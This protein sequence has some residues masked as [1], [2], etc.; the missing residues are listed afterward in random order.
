MP[1]APA[2]GNAPNPAN[3]TGAIVSN[4]PHRGVVAAERA[5]AVRGST[6]AAILSG[7]L[8]DAKP[9]VPSPA[10][11]GAQAATQPKPEVQRDDRQTQADAQTETEAET[12]TETAPDV[13]RVAPTDVD[14]DTSKRIAK[15]QEAERHKASSIA[16][17]Q[18]E[19]DKRAKA[20]EGEWAPRVKRA[21]DFEALVA[22]AAKA[23]SNP[24][25]LAELLTHL[26]YTED[27]F[28]AAGQA[29]YALSKA[30]QADPARK[31][32]AEKLMRDRESMSELEQ[33][34][35][36]VREL[37]DGIT[38]DK[39][40]Q[41]FAQQQATFLDHTLKAIGDDAP[42]AKALVT[43]NPTKLRA[44]LWATTVELTEAN[45]GDVP[46]FPEIVAAYEASRR[47]ELE[48]L[49]LAP[50]TAPPT[51]TPKKN[52]QPAEEKNTAR[53]L[54]N[55]LSTPRVPRPTQSGDEGRKASRKATLQLIE[56]GKLG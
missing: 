39:Q 12:P 48:E 31:A 56:S 17:K 36:E 14:A 45:D 10:R 35:A 32:Q 13:S 24:A 15:I 40:Q 42:I 30:G 5:K 1:D 34:R 11:N 29:L 55:D 33:L 41:T 47:A 46:D 54:S 4:Q 2:S 6:L 28:D 9:A 22:K 8:D 23:R 43:K 51:K 37:R 21:E 53:T 49:G 16:A 7:K 38:E 20:I 18:A 50:P 19:L 27:H 52:D 25:H 3:A 26:G 44:A